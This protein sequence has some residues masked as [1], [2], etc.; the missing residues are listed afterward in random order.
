MAAAKVQ[1][2]DIDA[3][4]AHHRCGAEHR[5]RI[6]FVADAARQQHEEPIARQLETTP[7]LD[8]LAG[9]RRPEQRCVH[10]VVP[11]L[12]DPG[13]ERRGDLR[14]VRAH[15]QR[16]ARQRAVGAHQSPDGQSRRRAPPAHRSGP[17]PVGTGSTRSARCPCRSRPARPSRRRPRW[18]SAHRA[19]SP[20]PARRRTRRRAARGIAA[21][22]AERRHGRPRSRPPENGRRWPPRGPP[23]RSIGRRGWALRPSDRKSR[24]TRSGSGCR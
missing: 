13:A 15:H 10:A 12:H 19:A 6:F 4:G 1:H 18:R 3:A 14:E 23:V 24:S 16:A 20:A 22:G 17:A 11:A 9:R 5:L 7:Q 2:R 8:P 21:T